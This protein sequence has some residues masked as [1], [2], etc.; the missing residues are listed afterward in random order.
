MTNLLL[1]VGDEDGFSFYAGPG[2]GFAW[3]KFDIDDA[4]GITATT[5]SRTAALPGN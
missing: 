2:V 4:E 1:D 5:T 3:G